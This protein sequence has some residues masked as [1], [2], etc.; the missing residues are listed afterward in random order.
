MSKTYYIEGWFEGSIEA[1]SELDAE[2]NFCEVDID[3][4]RIQD[5]HAEDEEEEEYDDES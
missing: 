2:L 3:S 1:E 4:I 5:V